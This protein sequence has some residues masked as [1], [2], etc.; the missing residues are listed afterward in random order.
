[1]L[2]LI[3]VDIV[4]TLPSLHIFL[5]E[6]GPLYDDLKSMLV[7][8]VVARLDEGFS[9]VLDEGLNYVYVPGIAKIAGMLLLQMPCPQAFTLMRNLLERH[10]LRSFYGGP[11]AKEDVR[12][13]SAT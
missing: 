10:C 1:V 2:E 6:T 3:E 5:P 11:S 7:A 8:W 4:E 9:Y 13:E 12:G